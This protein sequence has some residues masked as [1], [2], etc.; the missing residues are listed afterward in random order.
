MSHP[1]PLK[2]AEKRSPEAEKL[3]A[4]AVNLHRVGRID[5]AVTAYAQLLARFGD[6]AA[7]WGNL[8]VALKSRDRT[9]AALACY[10]RS[11]AMEPGNA[12]CW[13]N[14]GNALRWLGRLEEA[15]AA[16]RRAL[17]TDPGY[18]QAQYNL[19]L[20]LYDQGRLNEALDLFER[21]IAARPQMKE[22]HWDRALAWLMAGDLK[23]GF[24]GYEHRFDLPDLEERHFRQPRW[25]GASFAGKTLL[26]YSE[27]GYGDTIQFARFVP[28]VKARGGRVVL[29]CQAELTRLMQ[30]CGADEVIAKED[31]PP[32]FDLQAPLLST[33][34]LLGVD[35]D[36]LPAERSYLSPSDP[37][38]G[39]RL[40]LR[41]PPG[42]RFMVGVCWAGKPSQK[43]DRHRS[44]GLAPMLRL[45]AIPGVRLVSLQK[46]PRAR[47]LDA[48][49]ARP[50]VMDPTPRL[51]DFSDTAR[52]LGQLD[53]VVT[54]C[55]SVAHL[56]GALGVPVWILL[57]KVADWRWL[58]DQE[59][60]PW[61]PDARLFRQSVLDDWEAPMDRVEQELRL[62]ARTADAQPRKTS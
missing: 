54:V 5:Q 55:T 3:F 60:S 44:M 49:G 56:A 47:E 39:K 2:A 31:P 15:E 33:P 51:N 35:W 40:L 28:L 61:Y 41:R 16:H 9:E 59:D 8:G 25:D 21:A 24:E 1:D 34:H 58:L 45:A 27:Q 37:P 20:V 13:S 50:L 52:L 43:N 32:D 48:Q 46:G 57:T 12:G 19:A 30:S 29:E 4:Q 36:T 14:L 10:R 7:A 22:I 38:P 42:T 23:R 11:L 6:D 53:L 62:M 18:A 17:E 26:L